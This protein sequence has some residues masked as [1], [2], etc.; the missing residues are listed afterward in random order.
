MGIYDPR[1]GALEYLIQPKQHVLMLKLAID[2]HNGR[3]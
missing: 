2:D 1:V 3:V